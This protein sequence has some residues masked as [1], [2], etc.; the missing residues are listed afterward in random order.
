M[1]LNSISKLSFVVLFSLVS[2]I[3]LSAQ[4]G[5]ARV[6]GFVQD[7]EGNPLE[8][9]K[10]VGHNSEF[11]ISF[12]AYTN[13]KGHWA[14]GGLRGGNWRITA[15]AEGYLP[16]TVNIRVKQSS[17]NPSVDFRL[18]NMKVETD[19]TFESSMIQFKEGNRLYQ[20]K[21]YDEAIASFRQFLEE[22]PAIYQAHINIGNCYRDKGEY[23]K[24]IEEYNLVIEAVKKTKGS[25]KEDISAAKALANIGECY[26]KK[27]DKETAHGYL[28]KAVDIYPE[29]AN[30]AY[31]VGELC[32]SNNRMEEAINYFELASKINPLWADPFL[33]LGYVHLNQTNYEEALKS[34]R[35]FLD[36]A[37]D[38]TQA[39]AIQNL[40]TTLEKMKK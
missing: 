40:I 23:D 15:T 8:G 24:A 35:K 6:R 26:L 33:R 16:G 31:N 4:I 30:L 12:E 37:P 18:K 39:P 14:K 32:F 36:L 1:K 38:S 5:K 7:E 17:R 25:L 13:K 3:F 29:D 27:G 10:I 9:A 28:K 2:M 21:K 20:E 34:F 19:M 22:N 11:D